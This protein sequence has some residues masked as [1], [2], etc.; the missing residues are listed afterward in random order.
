MI[1]FRRGCNDRTA[2]GVVRRIEAHERKEQTTHDRRASVLVR[3]PK[4]PTLPAIADFDEDRSDDRL[5]K[6]ARFRAQRC[7]REHQ[8]GVLNAELL[9]RL[10][11]PAAKL[12]QVLHGRLARRC[13]ERGCHA[14]KIGIG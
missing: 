11:H 8:L 1:L 2:P 4:L 10:H 13:R 9:D 5:Q 6:F 3:N 14:S 12:G 7:A